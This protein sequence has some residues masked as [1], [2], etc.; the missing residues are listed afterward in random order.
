MTD[1]WRK[2]KMENRKQKKG[3]KGNIKEIKEELKDSRVY[4]MTVWIV[5]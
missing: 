1:P 5:V 3:G 4:G 2:E